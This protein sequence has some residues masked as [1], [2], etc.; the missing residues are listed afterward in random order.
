MSK[1]AM[2][3]GAVG[4]VMDGGPRDTHEIR[5]LCF[6]TFSLGTYAQDQGSPGQVVDD[7]SPIEFGGIALAS[8]DLVYGDLDG[9]LIIPANAFEETFAGA[10]EKARGEQHVRNVLEEGMPAKEAF[11]KFGI[12]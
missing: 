1:K 12:M 11:E 6:P 3:V 10:L 8:G 7:Q 9:G 4:A 5:A 2:K